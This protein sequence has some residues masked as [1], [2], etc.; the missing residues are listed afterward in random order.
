MLRH[1]TTTLAACRR[2]YDS[3]GNEFGEMVMG[4]IE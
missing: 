1:M 4:S 2:T 3:G